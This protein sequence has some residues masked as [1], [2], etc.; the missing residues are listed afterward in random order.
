MLLRQVALIS[1]SKKVTGPELARVSAALQ[2][3]VSRDLAP[4]WNCHATVDAFASE[5]DVPPGYWKI[6]VMDQIPAKGAAGFHLDEQGQPYADVEWSPTW[7]LTASHECLEML[8]D[9]FGHQVATGP[10]P[11]RDQARVNFLVEVCDPCESASHAYTINTGTK[12]EVLVSD[13]YTPEYFSP[14]PSTGIRY[15]FTGSITSPRQVLDGGYLS[16]FNPEDG[17]IW[18]LLGPAEMDNFRD[19]G[20]GTLNRENSDGHA[21]RARTA[22]AASLPKLTQAANAC[23][24]TRDV[25]ADVIR[26]VAGAQTTVQITATSGPVLFQSISYG[27]TPIGAGTAS[28]DF[29]IKAGTVPLTFTYVPSAP[30]GDVKLIDPCG[31][32]LFIFA[33]NPSAPTNR[34]LVIA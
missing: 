23:N 26:G 15:S 10:S 3:Q 8:V 16:W 33:N 21:R 4:I 34:R 28:V 27:G 24:L 25:I 9:P 11:K 17:H 19:Q 18:Q 29:Q 1:K 5:A 22:H 20:P 12:M 31:K 7:S 30:G 32:T 14:A 6:S 2:R 13:F